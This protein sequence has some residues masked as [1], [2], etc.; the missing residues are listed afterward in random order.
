[1]LTDDLV[2]ATD[3]IGKGEVAYHANLVIIIDC[4]CSNNVG[5]TEVHVLHL[6]SYSCSYN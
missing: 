5:N 3:R 4:D 1:M 6:V 2:S